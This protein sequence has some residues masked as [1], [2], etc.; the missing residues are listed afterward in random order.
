MMMS[1]RE[2]AKR[3]ASAVSRGRVTATARN[4]GSVLYSPT[5]R[6]VPYP[7]PG[8]SYRPQSL[9]GRRVDHAIKHSLELESANWNGF[10]ELSD[11]CRFGAALFQL[12][13]RESEKMSVTV[14][15]KEQRRDYRVRVNSPQDFQS[16]RVQFASNERDVSILSINLAYFTE[17]TLPSTD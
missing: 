12:K 4:A 7:V 1:S 2:Q 14:P 5:K 8:P 10:A 3:Y 13:T 16:A 6:A 9:E 17:E 15:V 11:E